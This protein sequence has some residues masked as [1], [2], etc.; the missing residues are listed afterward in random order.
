MRKSFFW[1]QIAAPACR[2]AGITRI[3]NSNIKN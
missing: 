2:Q 1:T 3:K